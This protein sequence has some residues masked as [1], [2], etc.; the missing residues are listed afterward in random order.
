VD[1]GG[2][3]C[4]S[5]FRCGAASARFRMRCCYSIEAAQLSSIFNPPSPSFYS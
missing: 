5:I 2:Q 1:C 4:R 3:G